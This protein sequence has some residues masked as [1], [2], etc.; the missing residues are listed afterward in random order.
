[1]LKNVVYGI[2]IASCFSLNAAQIS[3]LKQV[4][5]PKQTN[6]RDGLSIAQRLPKDLQ[7]FVGEFLAYRDKRNEKTENDFY[8][9]SKEFLP[10]LLTQPCVAR[11]KNITLGAQ[12][13]YRKIIQHNAENSYKNDKRLVITGKISPRPTKAD[14][15]NLEVS[16]MMSY[17]A[18]YD[19][20][21]LKRQKEACA[22]DTFYDPKNPVAREFFNEKENFLKQMLLKYKENILSDETFYCGYSDNSIIFSVLPIHKKTIDCLSLEQKQ[23]LI[24]LYRAYE[25]SEKPEK[26]HILLN[27][28]QLQILR[29]FP[30][31]MQTQILANYPI[32]LPFSTLCYQRYQHIQ[33]F[34]NRYKKT[35]IFC[36]VVAAAVFSWALW[37]KMRAVKA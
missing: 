27:N 4:S 29:S 23:F 34:I 11:I 19:Y 18:A 15:K 30:L 28:Q 26:I 32:K 37:K 3:Q 8:V 20:S 24:D 16:R 21:E 22:P 17:S 35:C 14:S 31:D 5:Q 2:L 6:Q 1:M 9:V 36:G 13:T 33:H 25:I 10:I 7:G 12:F